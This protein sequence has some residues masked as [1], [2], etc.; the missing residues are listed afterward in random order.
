[1]CFLSAEVDGELA[2]ITATEPDKR[3]AS[4]GNVGDGQ[5]MSDKQDVIGRR[6]PRRR[7]A[8]ERGQSTRRDQCAGYRAALMRHVAK[9]QPRAGTACRR[10]PAGERTLCRG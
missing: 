1:M 6:D 8:L 2:E 10:E 4:L 3:L 5:D 7:L 9:Q